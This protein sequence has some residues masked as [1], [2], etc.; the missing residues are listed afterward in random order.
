MKKLLLLTIP[1]IFIMGCGSE[2]RICPV[3]EPCNNTEKPKDESVEQVQNVPQQEDVQESS[4]E[5]APSMGQDRPEKPIS[6]NGQTFEVDESGRVNIPKTF[7]ICEDSVGVYTESAQDLLYECVGRSN[8]EDGSNY[9]PFKYF[10]GSAPR[11]AV[12]YNYG[13]EIFGLTLV[14]DLSPSRF[15]YTDVHAFAVVGDLL[16]CQNGKPYALMFGKFKGL[17]VLNTDESSLYTYE[18]PSTGDEEDFFIPKVPALRYMF[19]GMWVGVE[20]KVPGEYGFASTIKL[21]TDIHT[22]EQSPHN[23]DIYARLWRVRLSNTLSSTNFDNNNFLRSTLLSQSDIPTCLME[24]RATE[25]KT[26]EVK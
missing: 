4:Q 1:Y 5:Q 12:V 19:N 13:G 22:L 24:I 10:Q 20:E 6:F 9:V 18:R 15:S 25:I 16:Y 2:G 21:E 7:P 8:G 14:K 11:K 23:T 17:H 26:G 3:G